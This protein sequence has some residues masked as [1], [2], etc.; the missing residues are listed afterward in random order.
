MLL[1]IYKI[2]KKADNLRTSL[3]AYGAFWYFALHIL[4]NL[5]GILALI[6]LTGIPLAFL[7]YGGSY[8]LN[9]IVIA[10]IVERV[11]IENKEDELVRAIKS[12]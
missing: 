11:S 8:T 1:R 9:A 6:P 4:I 3:L 10:F 5:L 2:A 7:S 12:Y